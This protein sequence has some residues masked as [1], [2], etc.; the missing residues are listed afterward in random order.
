MPSLAPKKLLLLPQVLQEPL[1][2]WPEALGVSVSLLSVKYGVGMLFSYPLFSL[3][4]S[5][6]S[7]SHLPHPIK[8]VVELEYLLVYPLNKNVV[9]SF[10][11]KIKHNYDNS[12]NEI[13]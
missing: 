11:L 5:A 13:H 9:S 1:D 6:D 2:I 4:L 12:F 8:S 3:L 10:I 7:S